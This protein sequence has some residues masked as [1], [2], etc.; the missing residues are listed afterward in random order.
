M[1][2]P[3]TL[4]FNPSGKPLFTDDE[5]RS[6][7]QIEFDR[8]RRYDYP[9]ACLLIEVDRL[10]DIQTM[11]G[12]EAR[13]TILQAFVELLQ[14]E[15]RA[16]DLLGTVVDDRL[17]VLIPHT[18]PA[19]A[20]AI[21]ERVL[22]GARE[23]Q[24][25]VG[26]KSIRVSA[27]IGVAHNQDEAATSVATLERV[28]EEGLSVAVAS[29]G[30]QVVQTELYQLYEKEPA[31]PAPPAGDVAE[32]LAR[33]ERMGYRERLEGL[34]AEG[35]PLEKAADEIAEEVIQR[36]VQQERERWSR[37]L[38]MANARIEAMSTSLEQGEDRAG[39]E[40]SLLQLNR[41]IE[42]LTRSLETTEAEVARLRSAGVEDT[43]V[44]SVYREVQGLDSGENRADLKRELMGEIFKANLDLQSRRSA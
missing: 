19:A 35:A 37:D 26:G 33:A 22:K 30:G 1:P 12:Y 4:S 27:S 24:F 40:R 13:G 5:V 6:L 14:G 38:E 42:K 28:A 34:V 2:N 11:H 43:G 23:M 36:A 29:G 9:V 3:G 20:R 25:K 41:R 10:V 44:A 17:M 39:L 21:S 31:P 7:M 18:M 32:L 15:T 16:G 8:A